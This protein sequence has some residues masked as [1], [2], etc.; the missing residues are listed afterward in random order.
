VLDLVLAQTDERFPLTRRQPPSR[1]WTGPMAF[2]PDR[3][4]A[5]GLLRTP[6]RPD[7]VVV[8][9]GYNGYGGSYCLEAGHVAAKL[10]TGNGSPPHAPEDVFSPNRFTKSG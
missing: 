4:P 6:G 9:A 1:L 5:L 7:G 8:A 2:T 3:L 10:A